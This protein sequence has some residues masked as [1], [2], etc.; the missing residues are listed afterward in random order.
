[1]IP[2]KTPKKTFID[3]HYKQL[4]LE[5]DLSED[6]IQSILDFINEHDNLN[7]TFEDLLTT[8]ISEIR[9]LVEI[10]G[11]IPRPD[12][13]K[14]FEE[15][16]WNTL[17]NLYSKFSSRNGKRLYSAINFVENLDLTV[18]P[19]CNQGKSIQKRNSVIWSEK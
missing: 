5:S 1:M 9:S 12:K 3:E 6:I 15:A 19:Y 7:Y 4:K 13:S 18:C 8:S 2:I 10:I 17:V 16:H 11:E 14:V